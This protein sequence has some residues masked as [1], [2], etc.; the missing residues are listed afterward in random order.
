MLTVPAAFWA[1]RELLAGEEALGRPLA[2]AGLVAVHPVLWYYGADG[3]SHAA[4]A[5]VILVLFGLVI[6]MRGR[7]LAARLAVVA[8]FGLAGSLRPTIP[9]LGSPLLVWLFWGRPPRDWLLAFTTGV[10]AVALWAAPLIAVSGGWDVYQRANRALVGDLFI[11]SFSLFGSRSHPELVLANAIK[12]LW[13]A[14]V[15]LIPVVAWSIRDEPARGWRRVWLAVVALNVA[16]YGLV[17][18]AEA[19][20]LAAVAGLA[21]LV[22]AAW[23]ARATPGLRARAALAAI[24]CPAFFLLGPGAAPVP[25]HPA[26]EMP[27]LAHAIEVQEG[28]AIYRA[29]V[30]GAAAGRRALLLTDNPS[31]T[32][33]RR[34][35]LQ[36][37]N[38]AVALYI[39]AMPFD[40]QRIIDAW[41]IFYADGIMA[42][43]TGIPLE[44]GPPAHVA[45]PEPVE[46]VLVAPEASDELRLLVRGS[47]AAETASVVDPESG[48]AIDTL[49]TRCLPAIRTATHTI[50][51]TAPARPGAPR[52]GG[53]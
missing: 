46:L 22:P 2:A 38:I 35:P 4:E 51:L 50:E 3:Q 19:G 9:L 26:A 1:C 20:Y 34:I 30:C 39:K 16:F 8:A 29:A 47:C 45:L 11:A 18:A 25:G 24:A 23:P 17:Y 7:G 53:L 15:A 48:L 33:T 13:W 36:C 21:C 5:L 10:A 12:T 44:P 27:T 52:F 42:V 14:A 32:H 37:P 6:R 28:Q 43:P 49:S 41:M 40:P 31:N